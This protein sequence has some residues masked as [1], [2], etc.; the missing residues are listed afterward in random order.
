MKRG[1]LLIGFFCITLLAPKAAGSD[2]IHLENG[3]RLSGRILEEDAE[4]LTLE[5]ETL[6][7]VTFGKETV[8]RIVRD[9][10]H[11]PAEESQTVMPPE[12]EW[13]R[14]VTLGYN[15][16]QG[17]TEDTQLSGNVFM[18]RKARKNEVM[19]KGNSYYSASSKKMNAQKYGGMFRYAFSFGG[20]LAWYHFSK[21]EAGHDR[22]A[23]VDWRLTPS[24]GL[25]Y[26]FSDETDRKAM[27][28]LG[29]GWEHT[30]FRDTTSDRGA[31]VLVPRGFIQTSLLG[32]TTLSQEVTLWPSLGDFGEYR[33]RAETVLTDPVASGLSFRVSFI[34]EFE[35]DPAAGSKRN[36]ARLVSS[37]VYAF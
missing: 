27:A 22:F 23:N 9:P 5:H 24:T 10:S 20:E 15:L 29:V 25:G 26:W 34:D 31:P 30:V 28:E 4:R 2:V 16:S 18:N 8:H 37:F 17:N 33:L 19:V 13:K 21:V 6:G 12:A 3:D 35:S 36:D 1:L 7:I 32:D 11:A 14:E